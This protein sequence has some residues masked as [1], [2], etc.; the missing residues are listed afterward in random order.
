MAYYSF[1][2]WWFIHLQKILI[3]K[4]L[5]FIFMLLSKFIV[6]PEGRIIELKEHGAKWLNDNREKDNF[7]GKLIKHSEQWY[8]QV[9]L[10]I[11]FLFSVKAVSSWLYSTTDENTL[12]DEEEDEIPANSQQKFKLF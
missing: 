10:A 1:Y 9:A 6:F 7:I 11:L 8:V 3:M 5:E 4:P 2:R 12:V